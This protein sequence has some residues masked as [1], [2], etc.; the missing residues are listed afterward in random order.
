MTDHTPSPKPRTAVI[1]DDEPHITHMVARKLEQA[2]FE[3][4]AAG[5]G[6]QALELINDFMPSIV[7]TD[8]Q[9]PYMS[10][11]ELARKLYTSERTKDIP[12]VMLT[13][14]G[15]IVEEETSELP[16]IK[17]LHSK[18]FSPRQLVQVVERVIESSHDDTG[19]C[20]QAA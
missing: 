3:V 19:E 20:G 13:A 7:V 2:G 18:P 17:E 4:R 11:I 8:L 15:F 1:V 6:K 10:G 16:N 14:R 12:V 5:D 9:M